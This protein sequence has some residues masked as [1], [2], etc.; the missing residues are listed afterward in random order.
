MPK[1]DPDERWVR[2]SHPDLGEW[3]QARTARV[4]DGAKEVTGV[5]AANSQA[6]PLPALTPEQVKDR[7]ARAKSGTSKASATAAASKEA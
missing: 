3:T 4:P 6:V 7:D 5:P 2:L 1:A